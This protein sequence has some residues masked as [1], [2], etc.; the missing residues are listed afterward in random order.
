MLK[1]HIDRYYLEHLHA[2]PTQPTTSANFLAGSSTTKAF[3]A[4]Q[5]KAS[6][7]MP[8]SKQP[9]HIQQQL[10]AAMLT[11]S[12]SK[13]KEREVP[14]FKFRSPI[15]D[16]TAPQ[17]IL[18]HLLSLPITLSAKDVVALSLAV[19]KELRQLV[20]AK[21]VESTTSNEVF[22]DEP[23]DDILSDTLPDPESAR[24]LW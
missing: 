2:A 12:T 24:S 15:D 6:S 14:A 1:D 19:Q 20:T 18:D 21:R 3:A 11:V 5:K 10:T 17:H 22:A 8:K 9:I 23:P 7:A 4:K 16:A 13:G